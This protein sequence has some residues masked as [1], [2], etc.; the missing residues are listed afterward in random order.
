M[1]LPIGIL[2]L[3]SFFVDVAKLWGLIVSLKK[4]KGMAV[5]DGADAYGLSPVPAGDG[6]IS[7]VQDFHYLGSYINRD[8]ELSRE[9]SEHLANAARMFGCLCS[10]IFVNKRLSIDTKR[11]VYVANVLSTLLHW[12]ETWAVKAIQTRRI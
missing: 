3:S 7:L 9:V 4:S 11:Y 8:G 5:G 12:T 2:K 6:F 10:S 1:P